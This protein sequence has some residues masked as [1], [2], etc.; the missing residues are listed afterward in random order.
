[1][2]LRTKFHE[3]SEATGRLRM[4]FPGAAM[5]D[6]NDLTDRY[7]A[8]WNERDDSKRRREIEALWVPDGIECTKSRVVQ[9]YQPIYE[10]VTASHEKNVRDCGNVFRSCG[11]ADGHHGL[12]KFNWT[13]NSRE[14]GDLVATGAYVLVVEE[15]GRIRAAYFFN[16]PINAR[17]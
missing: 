12:I 6:F 2:E 4:S 8:L 15:S 10:R 7:V 13:M 14:T 9:G 16:E 11:N 17:A 1:M 3:C 5:T